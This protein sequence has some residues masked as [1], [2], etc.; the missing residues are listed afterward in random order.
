MSKPSCGLT[1]CD[2]ALVVYGSFVKTRVTHGVPCR[3]YNGPIPTTA[4]N[5]QGPTDKLFCPRKLP[6]KFIESLVNAHPA[7]AHRITS[8]KVRVRTNSCASSSWAW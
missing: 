7:A 6:V 1:G 3:L 2:L 8:L 5:C 4:P